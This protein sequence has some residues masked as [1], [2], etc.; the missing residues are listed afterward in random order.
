MIS[1]WVPTY[2][3]NIIHKKS[4]NIRSICAKIRNILKFSPLESESL[5]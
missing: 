3:H 2:G 5:L 1:D 4:G